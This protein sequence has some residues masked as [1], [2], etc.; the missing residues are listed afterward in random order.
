MLDTCTTRPSDHHHQLGM[1]E[2]SYTKR[3]RPRQW[4][5]ELELATLKL[6]DKL[7]TPESQLPLDH[8]TITICSYGIY[9]PVNWQQLRVAPEFD[10]CFYSLMTF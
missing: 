9:A 3:Q 1:D 2:V 4:K 10:Q 6:Y 7:L 8:P 5:L